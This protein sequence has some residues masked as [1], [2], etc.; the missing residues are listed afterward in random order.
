M[1]RLSVG[2]AAVLAVAMAAT[3]S[4]QSGPVNA[5][6][7]VKG[8]GAKGSITTTYKGKVIGFC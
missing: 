7:P 1:R 6:C 3:A 5:K 2:L 8:T 4:A